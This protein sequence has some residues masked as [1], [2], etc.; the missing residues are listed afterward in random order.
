MALHHDTLQAEEACAV[1]AAMIH[2]AF[3]CVKH[4]HRHQRGQFGQYIAVEFFAQETAQHLRQSFGG[5]QRDVA[6][7]TITH[8][9][10]SGSFENI[11]ALDVAKKIQVA[12]PEQLRGLLDHLVTLDVF[13]ADIQQAD[14]GV[15]FVF[16]RGDQ[17][18]THQGKLQQVLGGAIGVGAQVEHTNLALPGRQVRGNRG[19]INAGDGFQHIAR[20]RHQRTGIA[21]ADTGQRFAVFDQIDADPHRGI[22]LAAQRGLRRFVHAHHF[23]GWMN[24][25]MHSGLHPQGVQF[26]FNCIGNTHQNDGIAGEQSQIFNCSGNDDRR[27]VV[28]SHRIYS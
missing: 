15:G 16:Q 21:G 17:R 14:A 13:A 26:C 22:F 4:R 24:A 1:V 28:A 9:H 5:F 19:T 12:V 10:V 20:R 2:P 25:Q 8:H 23:S 11:I 6:D 3:E 18:G 27:A 7:E